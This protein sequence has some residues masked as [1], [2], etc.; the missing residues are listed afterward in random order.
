MDDPSIV[1][2][3]EAISG[4][5]EDLKTAA[6]KDVVTRLVAIFA[7]IDQQR[8]SADPSSTSTPSPLLSSRRPPVDPPTTTTRSTRSSA[9]RSPLSSASAATKSM[10]SL[11]YCPTPARLAMVSS[12]TRLRFSPPATTLISF[13]Q[14][15]DGGR[16]SRQE[17]SGHFG[18]G[19]GWSWSWVYV[20]AGGL[21]ACQKLRS[22]VVA[23]GAS[24]IFS[25]PVS[26]VCM[27]AQARLHR[28]ATCWIGTGSTVLLRWYTK[29]TSKFSNAF[30]ST[31]APLI[32][33][34]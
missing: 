3:A 13:G 31:S 30:S 23:D 12:T 32:P 7:L 29:S 11:V 22:P 5:L 21:W 10:L 15:G 25:P 1:K 19:D 17:A 4:D 20:R 14:G 9:A 8:A 24:R 18:G 16:R 2:N 26:F 27:V 28:L 6:K 34:S 33:P